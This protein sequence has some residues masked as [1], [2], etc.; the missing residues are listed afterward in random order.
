MRRLQLARHCCIAA[1]NDARRQPSHHLEH[2]FPLPLDHIGAL[3]H[4]DRDVHGRAIGRSI[5]EGAAVALAEFAPYR[6]VVRA[7]EIDVAHAK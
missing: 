6:D 3:E 5:A 7:R 2:V 1:E 4:T